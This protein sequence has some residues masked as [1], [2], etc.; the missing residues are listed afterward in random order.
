VECSTGYT[1]YPAD[2]GV[3]GRLCHHNPQMR[4]I[5][6]LRNP[7]DRIASHI[8]HNQHARRPAL[9]DCMEACL[10]PE[11]VHYLNVS[12]Y[13]LQLEQFLRYFR[14]NASCF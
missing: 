4:F 6:I 12:R 1:K 9:A 5:Y 13:Y 14:E 2:I 8:S 3:P 7:I 10:L 11:H